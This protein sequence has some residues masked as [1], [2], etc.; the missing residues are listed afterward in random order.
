[1]ERDASFTSNEMPG[2]FLGTD[3]ALSMAGKPTRPVKVPK[4]GCGFIRTKN[5]HGRLYYYW[6]KN[7][8]VNGKPRQVVIKYLGST[9]PR[10]A[11]LGPVTP[12]MA[13]KLKGGGTY[14]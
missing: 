10:G 8:E 9:L 14:H 6:V 7:T 11:R 2:G 1:M 3:V 12:K 5:I 13:A 4:Y